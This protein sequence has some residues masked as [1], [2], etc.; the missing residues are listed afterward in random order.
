MKWVPLAVLT[1]ATALAGDFQA[2]YELT[3]DRV[4]NGG[5]PTFDS[6]FVLADL[7]AT[8][9]RRFT[10]FSGDV[11]G[12]YIGALASAAEYSRQSPAALDRVVREAIRLQKPDGHFGAPLSEGK[13]VNSDMATLWG[14]G[15]ILIGLLEYYR[16]QKSPEVLQAARKLGDFLV[17][18]AP[19]FNADDVRNE[20]N[21]ARFAVGYICWTQNLEGVVELYR[22]TKEP[23]YLDLAYPMEGYNKIKNPTS[24]A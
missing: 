17:S 13:V 14:N 19:R 18:V 7:T 9:T 8:P 22:V 2:R 16:V 23:R 6:S 20:Y 21:G 24:V 11:S 4:L 12:R 15:R 1:A 5:S 3:V 10:N